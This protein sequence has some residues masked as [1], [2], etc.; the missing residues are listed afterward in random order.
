MSSRPPRVLIESEARNQWS[1]SLAAAFRDAG[2]EVFSS[3]R[4]V[5]GDQVPPP[6]DFEMDAAVFL[7]PPGSLSLSPEFYSSVLETA[8]AYAGGKAELKI[9]FMIDHTYPTDDLDLLI[10]ASE[11]RHIHSA[12]MSVDAADT[13]GPIVQSVLRG[14]GKK[15]AS[16][17][18][19]SPGMT[20]ASTGSS[21]KPGMLTNGIS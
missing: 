3:S 2:A 19:D 1:K 6:G 7:V 18:I 8:A 17:E 4:H 20:I 16:G 13:T 5:F 10:T 14:R 15:V 9:V 12:L 21:I 11:S